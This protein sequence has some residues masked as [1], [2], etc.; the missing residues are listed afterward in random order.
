VAA[1]DS[2]KH[3]SFP[4]RAAQHRIARRIYN[5]A[6]MPEFSSSDA[7]RTDAAE[8]RSV[9]RGIFLHALGESSISRAFEANV[10]NSRGVLRV[11]QD[12]YDLR[13]YSRVFVVSI[14]KAAHTM[15]NA[16]AREVPTGL[17]GIAV[18]S[19]EATAHVPGFRYFWGGH[20]LPNRES[21]RA[22]DAVLRALAATNETSLVIFMISGGGSAVIEK[23]ISEDITLDDLTATY[24]VLV[25]SGAPIAQINAIRKHLSS[26]KGGRLA[27]AALRARQVSILVSDVPENALDSLASGPTMPD[28]S[29][30]DDCYRIASE[31]SM[32]DKFPPSAGSIFQQRALEET[33]KSSEPAFTNSRWWTVLSNATAE[34]AAVEH[35]RAAGFAVEV[36]NS[37][38]DWDYARAADYLLDRVRVLR[39]RNSRVC[40]ISGGEV[41]VKVDGPSGVGGRNQQF[42]LYCATKIVGENICIASAGTDGID[43]VSPAAGAVV[44]GSTVDRA[45]QKE[46]DPAAS[47]K[48]FDAYP[49][50][51]AIGDDI[52]TGPTG[53]NV[54]DLRILLAY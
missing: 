31:Y 32:I 15:V 34:N 30:V 8:M 23:P 37:C 36:D 14:G 10:N 3:L 17:E 22:G 6:A 24:R 4:R 19:T 11:C 9:A 52:E 7:S 27:Q 35:A 25:N 18:G 41:T 1:V 20:P 46:F 39:Q 51:K 45:Q 47:L 44:D 28:T 16:L 13:A 12:L 21:I 50:F 53:T 33:P 42:A 40:L 29:T 48:A 26:I 2:A 43:G 49:L 54:R 5:A 38:D